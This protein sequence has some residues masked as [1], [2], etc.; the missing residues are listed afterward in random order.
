[1]ALLGAIVLGL[2]WPEPGATGGLLRL[3]GVN[4]VG[5]AAIFFLHGAML[6][7]RSLRAQSGRWRVHALIQ[8]ITFLVFPAICFLVYWF[9]A[10]WL[11]EETRIGIF[12]LG[13]L[14]S[15]ISSSI[16]M[17]SVARGNVPIAI[18]NATLSGLLGLFVTPALMGLLMMLPAAAVS[19]AGA[20][21][22]DGQA[23]SQATTQTISMADTFLRI[24]KLLMVPLLVGQLL[25]ALIG[26]W[27]QERRRATGL[28]ER[29]VIVLIVLNAFS[30]ATASG[31]WSQYGLGLLL[32]IGVIVVGLL[33]FALVVCRWISRAAGL[34]RADE[35]AVVFC[36]STKSLAN[37]APLAQIM[38]GA[39][40]VG[41][42]ILLPVVLYH[43]LQLIVIAIMAK[44]YA[45]AAAAD[46]DVAGEAGAAGA[47]PPRD[48]STSDQR[49]AS[50]QLH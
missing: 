19:L 34:A 46:E 49:D 10:S 47:P 48:T 35:V 21:A 29:G 30:N 37:A 2:V 14:S 32:K 44:S 39:S 7:P 4:Q 40:P 27:L 42:M 20:G 3:D 24:F 16:A 5:I 41:G 36:G 11:P 33:V 25:H 43:Q 17:T 22:L 13:A 1:M 8:G 9:G 15:T 18:F 12:F 28:F 23:I 31:L 38:F 50:D 6:A 45:R 26:R